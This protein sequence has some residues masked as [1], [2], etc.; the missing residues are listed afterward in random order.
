MDREQVAH[1]ARLARLRLDESELG[2]LAAE[3]SQIFTHFE[4]LRSLDTDGIE[5]A[6]YAVDVTGP[7]RADEPSPPADREALQSNTRHQRG[8][9]YIVPPV[10][11]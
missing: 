11:E 7:V 2:R 5:P 8:G 3:L 9:F 1:V 4:T 6:I 10:M